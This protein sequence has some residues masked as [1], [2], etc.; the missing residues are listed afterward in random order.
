FLLAMEFYGLREIVGAEDNPTI[1]NWFRDIGHSWVKNDETAWCSCFINWL[2]W[3][4]ELE[5]STKLNARSWLEHGTVIQKP[6]IGDVVILWRDSITSWKGHV[7]LYAGFEHDTVYILGGNQSNQ[8]NI[9]G[10]PSNRVLGYRRL[11]QI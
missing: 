6:E 10:Y 4:L 5:M 8:V 1:V 9:K 7:G 2:A 3:K 11:N